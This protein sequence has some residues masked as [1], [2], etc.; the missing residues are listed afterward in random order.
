MNLYPF[1]EA[2]KANGR[3]VARACAL[4]EVSRSAYYAQRDKVGSARDSVDAELVTQ[5]QQVHAESKGTYGVPRIHAALRQRGRRHSR[6]RIARLMRRVGLCG[7]APKR[8][9]TTTIPDPAAPARADLIR[10]DFTADATRLNARW[11][12]DITYIPTREG[13]LY[14]ATVIDI[15]SRRVVGWASADH[16]RTDLAR[17]N[18]DDLDAVAA[19]LNSRPRKT[20]SWKTPAEALNNHLLSLHQGGVATTG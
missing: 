11:C 8:W 3:N 19:A 9:R 18:R 20:L 6:K 15:A 12:G 17:W 1:I 4:F 13:W 10:R 2:E 7:R 5:I 14:L 16:M